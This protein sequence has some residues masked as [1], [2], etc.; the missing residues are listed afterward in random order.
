MKRLGFLMLLSCACWMTRSADGAMFQSE[1]EPGDGVEMR[2]S[3]RQI[4]DSPEFRDFKRLSRD[5]RFLSRHGE[6]EKKKRD[7]AG[8]R[9]SSSMR[10]LG[11]LGGFLG[12]AVGAVFHGVALVFLVAVCVLILYLIVKAIVDYERP[13]RGKSAIGTLSNV[14]DED[15][16]QPPG[17]L[18]AD[19][20]LKRAGELAREGR[21]REAI[22]QL[23][24]GAMSY[25]ERAELIKYRRGLTH[26]DYVRAVRD[27][28]TV[29]GAMRA[30]VRTYEPLGFGRRDATRE[31]FEQ[32]L[33]EYETGFRGTS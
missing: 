20:Y 25:V 30:M 27:D 32:T 3:V 13:A 12:G 1:S 19:V 14:E 7:G 21:Y 24:L 6:N 33:N 15:L 18:P 9:R 26:R 11:R 23:L 10:G 29:Y 28:Q 5:D 22:A 31:H 4:L 16:E 17:E 2:R 8:T